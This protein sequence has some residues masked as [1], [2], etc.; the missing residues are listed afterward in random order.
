M[1]VF[2]L[3]RFFFIFEDSDDISYRFTFLDYKRFGMRKW[4]RYKFG[5]RE[6]DMERN[7]R[8]NKNNHETKTRKK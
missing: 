1:K 8:Q 4:L 7:K 2:F 5:L 6:R 3:Y